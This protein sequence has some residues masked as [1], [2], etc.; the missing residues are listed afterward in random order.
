M[1]NAAFGLMGLGCDQVG[2]S[3]SCGCSGQSGLGE[4]LFSSEPDKPEKWTCTDWMNWHKALVQAFKQ[5]KF[6]SG[7]KYSDADAIKM[8]NEVF[9]TW[10]DKIVSGFFSFDSRQF[11]GY[12]SGFYTYIKSVGLT[13]VLSYF[14]AVLTPVA[15]GA[16]EVVQSTVDTTTNAVDATGGIVNTLKTLIPL[17]LTGLVVAG[18]YYVYKNYL[19]GDRQLQIGPVKA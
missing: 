3:C 5:G 13:D 8:A 4:I 15:S 19:K 2:L 10:W 7:I 11:C 9:M 18:G 1:K 6:K 16:T 14:Q 12:D 17:A